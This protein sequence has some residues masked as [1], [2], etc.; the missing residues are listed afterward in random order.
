MTSCRA[1]RVMRSVDPQAEIRDSQGGLA[2]AIA[3]GGSKNL[4][5][6]VIRR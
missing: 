2:T 3:I 4:D 6:G 5:R 1:R